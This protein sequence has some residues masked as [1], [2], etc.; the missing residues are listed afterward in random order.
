MDNNREKDNNYQ[1]S[2]NMNNYQHNN[3]NAN[4][5]TNYNNYNTNNNQSNYPNQNYNNNM[6]NYNGNQNYNYNNQYS[7]N[8]NG[9]N[10]NY[11]GYQNINYLS[12]MNNNIPPRNNTVK[13]NEKKNLNIKKIA[14]IVI[15]LI[16]IC[17]IAMILFK[18]YNLK[19][20]LNGASEV[21]KENMQ[22]KSKLLSN[23]YITLPNAIR[24][25]GEVIGYSRQAN[26]Q[27]AEYQIG[28]EIEMNG[29][30]VLYVISKKDSAP[31]TIDKS[32]IDELGV[33][34]DGLKCTIYNTENTCSI[35]V[36]VFNKKGYT[37]VGYSKTK[38]SKDVTV[39][40]GD[41]VQGGQTLYPVY[42]TFTAGKA[43]N[44]K[45]SIA[46]NN[47]YVDIDSSFPSS[48]IDIY[49]GYVKNIEK[50]WPFLFH[51]QKIVLFGESEFSQYVNAPSTS[52]SGATFQDLRYPS[53]SP[54]VIKALSSPITSNGYMLI[55]HELTHSLDFQYQGIFNNRMCEEKDI[56][57]LYNKYEKYTSNR[58]L[59]NYAYSG[60]SLSDPRREF[61]AELMTFYYINYVDTNYQIMSESAY[62]RGNFPEDM[63]QAA[64]KY[65][66]IAQNNFD[67]SKCS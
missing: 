52:T 10:T 58:P 50:N 1:N 26:S 29:D 41:K 12:K 45:G 43:Y 4:Y 60:Y 67:K 65:I 32:D 28:Q 61:F 35:T 33:S 64:E 53:L 46:L 62:K 15:V 51:G 19:I 21:E 20:N 57:D 49:T 36:P 14:L 47:A 23:C 3:Y 6:N 48:L 13:P 54:S 30:L 24:T 9:I 16:V 5:G 17:V 37:N 40:F 34:A 42:D 39:H 7:N 18:N 22:C 31:L 59:S 8:Y 38:G 44:V 56:T 66:C 63:K 11:N 27:T 2:N 55:V 25:D